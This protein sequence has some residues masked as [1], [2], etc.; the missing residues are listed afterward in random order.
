MRGRRRTPGL[1]AIGVLV[2]LT[3]CSGP[4]GGTGVVEGGPVAYVTPSHDA[5]D[6]AALVGTLTVDETCLVIVDEFDARWLPVFQR[7]RTT[8]DGTTLTYN[9]RPYRDGSTIRLA[10]GGTDDTSSAD[11]APESCEF[12]HVF[13]VGP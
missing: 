8:W 5:G 1:G 7:P 11:Y 13:H 4:E 3:G 2:A 10:G 9:G 12:D 6:S